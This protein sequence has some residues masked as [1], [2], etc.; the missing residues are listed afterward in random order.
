[1][2]RLAVADGLTLKAYRGQNAVLL[3]FD[4]E[5]SLVEQLA[6]FAVQYGPPGDSLRWINSR[7]SFEEPIG[8]EARSAR[9]R[10]TNVAPIQSFHLVHPLPDVVPGDFT[11]SATA[12]LFA[13]STGTD[14]IAGPTATVQL[15][16]M[17]RSQRN[18]ELGFTRGSLEPEAYAERFGDAAIVPRSPAI[19]FDTAP[20]QAAY[21]W[22][23]SDARRLVFA[24]LEEA[25]NDPATTLDVFAFDLDEPD[26]IRRL[27]ALGPRLR[28]FLD[29]AEIHAKAGTSESQARALLAAS[30][31]PDHVKAGHFRRFAH[32][33]VLILRRQGT[34]VKVLAGSAN[35]TVRGLYAQTNSVFVLDDARAAGLY[36]QAFEQAW[37]DP[38]KF[39]ASDVAA[40]WFDVTGDGL[41]DC[42]ISFSPHG[43]ANVALDQIAS[44]I[45]HASSSVLFSAVN[46]NLNRTG[47]PVARAILDLPQRQ[48]LY[49]VGLIPQAGSGAVAAT[50]TETGSPFVRVA[51]ASASRRTINTAFV[52]C[53][54]NETSPVVFAGSSNFA[55]G[56]EAQN[57]DNIVA[58]RD[59]EVATAFA[60]KAMQLVEH[61]RFLAATRAATTQAATTRAATTRAATTQAGPEQR[62]LLLSGPGERWA[63]AYFDPSSSRYLERTLLVRPSPPEPDGGAEQPGGAVPEQ[64]SGRPE[65][66][67]TSDRW[68]IVDELGYN[69]YADALA[70]FILNPET[71]TPLAIS[72][73]G[74]WGT[75][76]TSLMR[77]LRKR[78]D[79]LSPDGEDPVPG[80][81]TKGK[82]K[83]PTNGDVL[84][85]LHEPAEERS[86]LTDRST[87]DRP[88]PARRPEQSDQ[89]RRS[90]LPSIWFN[91]W[92]YQSSRQ[93]WAGL[94]V[95]I[96][97][98]VA[99]RMSFIQRERFWLTLQIRRV[100]GATLRRRLY[101]ELAERVLPKAA[102]LLIVSLGNLVV[103]ALHSTLRLPT[104][105]TVTAGS[106]FFAPLVAIPVAAWH[107]R[108]KFLEESLT[109][110]VSD[111]VR[112]PDY[113][114]EA[115]F[116]HLFHRDMKLILE[117]AGVTEEK[118]LVIFVDDLDRCTFATVAE[119][120]EG[121][122]LF[123]AGQF[124]HCVFV[125]GMEPTLVAAQLAVAYKDLF[126]TLSDDDSAAARI[127][128][129]WR[130]LEKMVQLP[131]ALPTPRAARLD[132][133]VGSLTSYSAN[134]DD[135]DAEQADEPGEAEIDEHE[136][137]LEKELDRRGGSIADIAA[138]ARAVD[139]SLGTSDA[140]Q[141]D[142][143]NRPVRASV[144]SAARRV[145]SSRANE[146]D[147]A[148]RQ[149]YLTYAG[150]LSGNP[151]EFKRF[152]NL[153]RF[154]ANLQITRELSPFPA[155]SLEQLAKITM[156]VVR[157]P[158]LVREFSAQSGTASAITTLELLAG[159]HRTVTAWTSA[160]K[161]E[162]S[163]A[164][165]TCAALLRADVH[166]FLRQGPP[167]A[168]HA[169]EFL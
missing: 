18:F 102:A 3:A 129:G 23:G 14:L 149:M 73:K 119:V 9:T 125:I 6:G 39:A 22:L 142:A 36:A 49:A 110:A 123:L 47:G 35:F 118:P 116:L 148:V 11:Y 88:P 15:E 50:Q 101:R 97:N 112:E 28:I 124:P 8:S 158:Y 165:G 99:S 1:M 2:E 53:D 161:K 37:L 151:R 154:Y 166:S 98:G 30:A 127:R 164:D 103:W 96:I 24:V 128:Y 42:S 5:E 94:A 117:A 163:L 152:L 145:V 79:P 105:V 25:V 156:L 144:I 138:A 64:G 109:S 4:V 63:A 100:D 34:P 106:L 21:E 92:I 150:Q 29:D 133:Y 169:D 26:V 167:I 7:L 141:E 75:G 80:A 54:F 81:A 139:A 12:M 87:R 136:Q 93:L 71:P 17:R 33:K 126:A 55:A 134:G 95:A 135:L 83:R 114:T 16:L 130:F 104:A 41:P 111:L 113:T 70:D 56:G 85:Q 65:A 115:G 69:V 38:S 43:H 52:V 45:A 76:K 107:A 62:P 51:D 159:K 10:P 68:T 147:P 59:R 120:V 168:D 157:W 19:D 32:S 72:I 140:V 122:N 48:G 155:P 46:L 160:A 137:A 108:R 61:H 13:R 31:G 153:F 74:E 146:N 58:F 131:V 67:A 82:T 91:A 44:A 27:A 84:D 60:V 78:I 20:F 121:L 143:A 162:R 89:P 40:G 86:L 77:M 57:G 90:G 66:R 132:R